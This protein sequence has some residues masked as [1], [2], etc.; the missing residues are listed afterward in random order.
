MNWEVRVMMFGNLSGG[1][2]MMM[3]DIDGRM[4]GHDRGTLDEWG[5][6]GG[7]QVQMCVA[8]CYSLVDLSR[9]CASQ[10]RT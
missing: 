9:V 7:H 8:R 10:I 5:Y 6:G 4:E 1:G 2:R 3:M